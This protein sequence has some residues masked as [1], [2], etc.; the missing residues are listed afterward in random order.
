MN[1]ETHFYE[2]ANQ[3]SGS[4]ELHERFPFAVCRRKMPHGGKI[5]NDNDGLSRFT[6]TRPQHVERIWRISPHRSHLQMIHRQKI[7][8]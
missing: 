3:S 8:L 2:E 7:M 6:M 5:S 4:V 1:M